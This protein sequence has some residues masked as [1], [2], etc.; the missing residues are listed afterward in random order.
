[1]ADIYGANVSLLLHCDGANGSTTFTDVSQNPKTVTATVATVSTTQSKW[2]GA[3][4]T[5]SGPT[6][7]RLT[8][9]GA[10]TD[11]SFGTGDFTIEMWVYPTSQSTIRAFY[12][13]GV[14]T[15]SIGNA[16]GSIC[17]VQ[18]YTQW[19]VYCNGSVKFGTGTGSSTLNTWQH[20]ALTRSGTTVSL[21]KN[22]SLVNSF[23]SAE[24]LSC[25]SGRPYIGTSSE[26]A[27]SFV[28]AY[29]YVGY[30][31]D[32]RVTK[33]VARYTTTFTPPAAAFDD[34]P[35]PASHTITGSTPITVTPAASQLYIRGALVLAGATTITVTPYSG[36]VFV[37]RNH[38]LKG[39]VK[40]DVLPAATLANHAT[41]NGEITGSTTI[42]AVPASTM[43]WYAPNHFKTG[44]VTISVTP[45]TTTW[46]RAQYQ[47][48][49]AA[50]TIP[51]LFAYATGWKEEPNTAAL[52][53]PS[54]IGTG[55]GGGLASGT[56]PSLRITATGTQELHGRAAAILPT[57]YATA[58]GQREYNGTAALVVPG[59]NA[60]SYGAATAEL[61]LPSFTV[62][63]TGTA[64]FG[65][66][67]A[68]ILPG[69]IIAATGQR[70]Y[71]GTAA[72]VLPG[73][74]GGDI[75]RAALVIPG[76]FVSA[77]GSV[78]FANSVGYILN[79]HTNE[80]FEWTNMGFL[81]II[82]IGTDFYGVKSTGLYKLSTAYTTDSGTPINANIL[83]KSTDLGSFHSKRLQYVYLG[84][85]TAT[86][87]TPYVDGIVK[88]SH[89]SSFGGKKTRLA[90]GNSGRY[91]QLK[92]ENI[93]ELTNLELLPQELQRRVK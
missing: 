91:W 50:L 5:F 33:G 60:S 30:I 2:G 89:L 56:L 55:V 21:F 42:T 34:P 18:W 36:K 35:P 44:A 72:L 25:P 53:L 22:G 59:F 6:N 87:L 65:G 81:H 23:T 48:G 3:S 66:K 90:L 16:A 40:V 47:G 92:V 62:S 67:A 68:C 15:G 31:D 11:C 41:V 32:I 7:N 73:L 85:E 69:L 14:T 13:D 88:S 77:S 4:A 38:T 24:N 78:G 8:V 84:S 43:A 39:D 20:I 74:R 27:G 63:G 93:I 10:S 82:R 70:E 12:D 76:L 86:K 61:I 19:N 83:T 46:T 57:L 52:V 80:S 37:S 75:G 17:I 9:A 45:T 28:Y 54:L 71:T 29:P 79:V 26:W 51:S 1:M 58:T 49:N 64:E